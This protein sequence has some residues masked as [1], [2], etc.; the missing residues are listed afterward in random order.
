MNDDRGCA[1]GLVV[2]GFL[3]ITIFVLLAI[4]IAN[5]ARST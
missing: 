1:F 3:W 4:A 5:I 2:A